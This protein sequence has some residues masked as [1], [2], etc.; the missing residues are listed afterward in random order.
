M[1]ARRRAF[2]HFIEPLTELI[3]AAAAVNSEAAQ[4][5][6]D[7]SQIWTFL[8]VDNNADAMKMLRDAFPEFSYD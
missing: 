8:G 2:G 7:L 4:I 5:S 6:V 1:H 3:E